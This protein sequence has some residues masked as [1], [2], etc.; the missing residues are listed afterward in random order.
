M[1]EPDSLTVKI[2]TYVLLLGN[3]KNLRFSQIKTLEVRQLVSHLYLLSVHTGRLK[4]QSGV[5]LCKA[6]VNR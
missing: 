1:L 2:K 3:K 6:T 4:D 5:L